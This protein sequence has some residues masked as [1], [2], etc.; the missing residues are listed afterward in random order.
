MDFYIN[1]RLKNA[2]LENKRYTVAYGG[3]GSGKSM[4][5]AA[6]C[7]IHA[8]ENADSR[9]LCIRGNQ[10]RISESSLQTLKDVVSMM[11][12]DDFF[13]MTENTLKCKNG[14]DFILYGAKNYHSFKSLQGV[15]LVWIDEAIEL[16]EAAWDTL[17]PTIRADGSR[18]LI[19]FNPE[20]EEDWVWDNFVKKK[21][22][23]A[24]VVQMN[25]SDN[26]FFP[27]ELKAEMSLDKSRDKG[28]YEHIWLG[29]LK[30]DLEGALWNKSMFQIKPLHSI[31][32]LNSIY[33][34]VDP[35]GTNNANSDTCGIIVVGEHQDKSLWILDDATGIMSPNTWAR[36]SIDLYNK[37]E[38]NGIIAETNYGGDMV[39]TIINNIDGK[40]P[41]QGVTARRS[42]LK[43]A[44]PVAYLYE[45]GKV[46][47]TRKF[48][49]LEYELCNYTGDKKEK[50]PGRLDAL[51]WGLSKYLVRRNN[52]NGMRAVNPRLLNRP[53]VL[54]QKRVFSL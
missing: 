47:H 39:K 37:W 1:T 43:R 32:D 13:Y 52:P 46:F 2:Y 21:H 25:H 44:E 27:D 29:K 28:K 8:V 6:F 31:D 24:A 48:V 38:A 4:Q 7:I 11:E 23:N 16:T 10:N 12:L 19:S 42:K 15:N 50:S 51:V 20:Y 40:I 5:L 3:R 34:A 36:K 41:V 9:I 22:P 53:T 17:I 33:I 45:T 49:D 14:S 54:R 26:P 18:F 30:K 35:S